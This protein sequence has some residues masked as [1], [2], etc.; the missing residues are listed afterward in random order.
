MAARKSGGWVFADATERDTFGTAEGVS[1]LDVCILQ[2]DQTQHYFDGAAW[3]PVPSGAA[4]LAATLAVGNLTGGTSITVS[5]GD[6]II[7]IDATVAGSD[8]S[9]YTIRAGDHT[10]AEGVSRA[11]GDLTIRG[12]DTNATPNGSQGGALTLTSGSATPNGSPGKLTATGGTGFR[13]NTSGLD[14]EFGGA[15]LLGSQSG[16]TTLFR[17]TDNDGTAGGG[18][19]IIRGGDALPTGTA[20]SGGGNLTIRAGNYRANLGGGPPAAGRLFLRGAGRNNVAGFAGSVT[21]PVKIY[22]A[23]VADAGDPTGNYEGLASVVTGAITLD[24][25]AGVGV[26]ATQGTGDITLRV[27]DTNAVTGNDP[28]SISLTAG[29]CLVENNFVQGG[30]LL[31][32]AGDGRANTVGGGGDITLIAGDNT[33]PGAPAFAGARGGNLT[34]TAGNTAA[35]GVD[36]AAGRVLLEGGDGTGTNSNGGDVELAPGAATGTGAPGRAIID[37]LLYPSS[38]GTAG[39]VI[40]TDGSADLSFQ[41]IR[42]APWVGSVGLNDAGVE[43]F[44]SVQGDGAVIAA[45][46]QQTYFL[47]PAD[48]RGMKVELR[49]TDAAPGGFPGNTDADV[50]VNRSGTSSETVGPVNISADQ[51][52]EFEFTSPGVSAGDLFS[53]GLTPTAGAG[54]FQVVITFDYDWSTV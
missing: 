49:S 7:G 6:A 17:G 22:T 35:D 3:Q 20:N 15:T 1:L 24:T 53:I 44:L 36:S 4:S 10:A 38:D 51:A 29:S 48:L 45:Q 37:G 26:T 25:Q 52:Y 34:L 18:P 42:T 11:G 13:P 32:T 43:V 30:S 40:I 27:G 28:G 19:S 9:D 46:G 23:A 39:Q 50:Y 2:S 31:F 5:V 16:G 47:A 33:R 41:T 12:G 14:A 54:E 21:G 8:G